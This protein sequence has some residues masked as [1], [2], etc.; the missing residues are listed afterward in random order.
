[1]VLDPEPAP[2]LD[3]PTMLSTRPELDIA[4]FASCLEGVF[5]ARF[6]WGY[7]WKGVTPARE[8][9]IRGY[10]DTSGKSI[11]RADIALLAGR[12]LN[13]FAESLA[14][15]SSSIKQGLFRRYLKYRAIRLIAGMEQR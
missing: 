7:D 5:P 8:A 4:H 12:L 13:G 11:D 9:L 15:P 10:V 6:Y 3:I 1:V 14:G 2:F